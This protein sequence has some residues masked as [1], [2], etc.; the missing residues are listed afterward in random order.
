MQARLSR[1]ERHLP[2]KYCFKLIYTLPT[3]RHPV[4]CFV[5]LLGL[6]VLSDVPVYAQN[7][8]ACQLLSKADA[9]VVLGVTLQP[10]RP[11][12]PF[13]SLL[14]PDFTKG[15]PEQGC[16]FTILVPNQPKPPR[17]VAFGVEVRYSSTPDA[18]AVDE[19]HKQVDR[20]TYD[21]PT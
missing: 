9:E 13:R 2:A 5:L 14:D 20:R 12:A 16:D 10:P 3:M 8:T 17:V 4:R 1:L 19:T 7:K 15:T 21:H 18:H 11:T 6:T